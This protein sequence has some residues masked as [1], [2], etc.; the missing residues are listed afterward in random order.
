MIRLCKQKKIDI[1][2][3]KSIQRFSRN[4]LDC[5]NYTRILRGLGIGVFLNGKTLIPCR[6]KA[7]S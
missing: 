4:T 5:I 1:I 7:S 6:R 2:L 3:T